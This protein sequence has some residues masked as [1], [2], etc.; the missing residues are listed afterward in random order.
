MLRRQETHVMAPVEKCPAAAMRPARPTGPSGIKP[1]GCAAD[2][3]DDD[4]D[5]DE[6]APRAKCK[7]MVFSATT[8]KSSKKSFACAC[9]V[10]STFP[11]CTA[12]VYFLQL[13]GPH[14]LKAASQK[15]LSG[16]E[17]C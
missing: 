5:D 13:L 7:Q 15:L 6:P 12:N 17:S 1:S 14:F 9:V 2:W 8:T 3:G 11:S 10:D 4:D 16:R